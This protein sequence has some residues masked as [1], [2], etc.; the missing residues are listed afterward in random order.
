MGKP[1]TEL[2]VEDKKVDSATLAEATQKQHEEQSSLSSILIADGVITRNEL[3]EFLS[4][5]RL[6]MFLGELLLESGVIKDPE[7]IEEGLNYQRDFGV[8]LGEAM[9]ELG[10][11]T[12]NKLIQGLCQQ[13][14]TMIISPEPELAHNVKPKPKR[15]FLE[16]NHVLP[17]FQDG[18]MITVLMA[19][20]F[21]ANLVER[22]FRFYEGFN[23]EIAY[24]EKE[25]LQAFFH[26]KNVWEN[27]ERGNG[28]GVTVSANSELTTAGNLDFTDKDSAENL[29]TFHIYLKK[30]LDLEASDIHFEPMP[31]FMRIRFAIDGILHTITQMPAAI[32]PRIVSLVKAAC[33]MDMTQRFLPG[34]G[35]LS[36]GY[37]G[38]NYDLRIST[39]PCLYGENLV[40]RILRRD[41]ALESVKD[42]GF[43]PINL[44]RMVANQMNPSGITIVTGPT[45]SGKT[46]TLYTALSDLA[47][48]ETNH[49]ITIEDPVEY[50]LDGITQGTVHQKL[51][52]DYEQALTSIMRQNPDVIMVGEIRDANCAR[53]VIQAALTGHKVYTTFHTENATGALARLMDMGVENFLVS[54]TVVFVVAQRLLRKICPECIEEYRPDMALITALSMGEKSTKHLTFRH[55]SGKVLGKKCR[56]CNG[57]GYKGRTGIHEI[58]SVNEKVSRA[59]MDQQKAWQIRELA[60]EEADLI[61]LRE[62]AIY[63][64]AKGITTVEEALRVVPHITESTRSTE[65]IIAI[66]E[67]SPDRF[68]YKKTKKPKIEQIEIQEIKRQRVAEAQE[69][70]APEIHRVRDRAGSTIS[71]GKLL[72]LK[73]DHS[74]YI[75]K[76][77]LH[78]K[79][80]NFSRFAS[81]VLRIM[82]KALT[83]DEILYEKVANEILERTFD[84]SLKEGWKGSIEYVIAGDGSENV[85][86][87]RDGEQDSTAGEEKWKQI[88]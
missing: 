33:G 59:I 77:D 23:I 80:E 41:Q 16:E 53:A 69:E 2:L 6:D 48:T 82:D 25:E 56:Y 73:I 76:I 46:T 86:L 38:R 47:S 29:K 44:R 61:S 68:K 60:K 57:S 11:V 52:F 1:F 45:G 36:A 81:R 21:N 64:I 43:S 32:S 42:L 65:E 55:G 19:D 24:A 35:R 49:I 51:G 18:N 88:R 20:P 37:Q 4:K 22:V 74:V 70:E 26:N 3:R 30:A 9:V 79:S 5:H 54:E 7:H 58:L 34:D 87:A 31:K 63:K 72:G 13:T 12:H 85:L 8:K 84:I 28:D 17:Y 78:I 14:N 10:Y 39:Y 75:D 67:E 66:S 40:V 62:D 71:F 27:A 50:T 15:K 83:K